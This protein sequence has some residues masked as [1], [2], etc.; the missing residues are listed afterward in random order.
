VGDLDSTYS[1]KC[2]PGPLW[3]L[4]FL[5]TLRLALPALNVF[6]RPFR[7]TLLNQLRPEASLNTRLRPKEKDHKTAM[8]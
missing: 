4:T 8:V 7:P 6:V 2:H 3:Y 1:Y 5:M